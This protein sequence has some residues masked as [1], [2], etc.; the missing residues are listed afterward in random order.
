MADRNSN[1][2]RCE[3]NPLTD[4]FGPGQAE[5][6]L[7]DEDSKNRSCIESENQYHCEFYLAKAK[8]TFQHAKWNVTS[9]Y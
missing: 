9:A 4:W 7:R 2:M 1:F 5:I 8:G 3:I 6:S